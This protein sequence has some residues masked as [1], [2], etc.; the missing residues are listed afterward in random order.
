MIKYLT[1]KSAA[2]KKN[3][4]SVVIIS[5]SYNCVELSITIKLS[6]YNKYKSY[7]RFNVDDNYSRYWQLKVPH[8]SMIDL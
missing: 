1:T 2:K 6:Y 7:L 5:Q 4:V 8:S 3:I